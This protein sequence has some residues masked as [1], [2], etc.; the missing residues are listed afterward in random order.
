AIGGKGRLA[1]ASV[2]VCL[3]QL[4]PAMCHLNRARETC[5]ANRP[6][7][8]RVQTPGQEPVCT[9]RAM[10]TLRGLQACVQKRLLLAESVGFDHTGKGIPKRVRKGLCRIVQATLGEPAVLRLLRERP[11]DAAQC[12]VYVSRIRVYPRRF[13]EPPGDVRLIG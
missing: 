11:T 12:G 5:P 7:P 2:A 1:E 13:Q 9:Q 4:Q 10:E 8:L 3:I 6:E